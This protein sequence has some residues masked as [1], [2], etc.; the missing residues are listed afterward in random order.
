M[1]SGRHIAGKDG[2]AVAVEFDP[3]KP[4]THGAAHS[5]NDAI[6]AGTAFKALTPEERAKREVKKKLAT[7]S[8]APKPPA[9]SATSAAP[10]GGKS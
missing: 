3:A 5:Y 7:A 2:K 1:K 4:D 6:A 10:E 8:A 9:A